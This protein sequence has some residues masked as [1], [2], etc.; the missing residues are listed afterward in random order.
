MGIPYDL[1]L[2]S[3]V[4][5]LLPAAPNHAIEW[6]EVACWAMGCNPA[7]TQWEKVFRLL[8][9][10]KSGNPPKRLDGSGI[11]HFVA[12]KARINQHER[13]LDEDDPQLL[14]LPILSLDQCLDWTGQDYDAILLL[15]TKKNKGGY[16]WAADALGIRKKQSKAS[17]AT[18][19][20]L[21]AALAL[22]RH[23]T[24]AL[25]QSLVHLEPPPVP[26]NADQDSRVAMED[27]IQ[28]RRDRLDA[29]NT[30]MRTQTV[31]VPKK[32]CCFPMDDENP[33]R[34]VCKI[35]FSNDKGKSLH[36]PPDPL[37]LVAQAAVVF[38]VRRN[39]RLRA[40][41]V[42][43]EDYDWER[44]AMQFEYLEQ[45]ARQRDLHRVTDHMEVHVAE[46]PESG[47]DDDNV[48]EVSLDESPSSSGSSGSC[49]NLHMDTT[50]LPHS[51]VRN[52]VEDVS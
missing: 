44:D 25:V 46:R 48:S 49:T 52:P 21:K 50:D 38:S 6:Y 36:P 42:V 26:S 51:F 14:L 31:Q 3:E 9:G 5:H 13:L 16:V 11:R 23:M 2:G 32:D 20:E 17:H 30:I 8:H 15:G 10:T 4:A 39:F 22:M 45:M 7:T 35:S 19:Q 12:N 33:F 24:Y 1:V 41:D 29:F 40:S 18:K 43:E 37:L 47:D 27:A 28:K 34:G